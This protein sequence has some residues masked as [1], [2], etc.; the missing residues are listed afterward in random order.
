MR[1]WLYRK[2]P[3]FKRCQLGSC[4]QQSQE[5]PLTVSVSASSQCLI[6]NLA[7]WG[8]PGLLASIGPAYIQPASL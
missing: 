7:S 8:Q 2:E 4:H 3:A 1:N 5:G 6:D